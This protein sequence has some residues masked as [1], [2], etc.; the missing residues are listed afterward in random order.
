MDIRSCVDDPDFELQLATNLFIGNL[1][2][3]K[4][5]KTSAGPVGEEEDVS[6]PGVW[7]D[8][9]V[10]AIDGGKLKRKMMI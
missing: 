5:F 9:G 6:S 1:L 10:P 4:N 7:K 3:Q 8:T 2:L